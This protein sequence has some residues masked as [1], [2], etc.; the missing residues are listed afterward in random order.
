[1][2]ELYNNTYYYPETESILMHIEPLS[3]P[4]Q[5]EHEGQRFQRK[6]E[7]H[8][9]LA[10]LKGL[11]DARR[12]NGSLNR[13]LDGFGRELRN[14]SVVLGGMMPSLSVCSKDEK[15]KSIITQA[16]VIGLKEAV[17]SFRQ[18]GPYLPMPYPH[19]TLY[20]LG[21]RR[22][23]GVQNRLQYSERCKEVSIPAIEAVI[24]PN[25]TQ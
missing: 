4:R 1:M 19:V 8:I 20:T 11:A 23:V 13:F 7:L 25:A 21:N 3:L 15:N 9:T 6:S 12:D 14:K 24:Y 17:L 22:G 18:T 2:R 10:A 16:E 5:I